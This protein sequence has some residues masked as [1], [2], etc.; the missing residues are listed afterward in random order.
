MIGRALCLFSLALSVSACSSLPTIT[1]ELARHSRP[2]VQIDG[3]RGPL[4]AAQSKAVLEGLQRGGKQS[5]L[6]ERHLALEQ[7]IVGSPLSTGNEVILLQDGPATYQAMVA[8]IEAARHEQPVVE[9]QLQAPQQ[10][11]P[12]S[13][14]LRHSVLG[15]DQGHL[16]LQGQRNKKR[17]QIFLIA[18]C[19]KDLGPPFYYRLGG[20]PGN[21]GKRE[22]L[23]V[24]DADFQSGPAQLFCKPTVVQQNYEQV[25]ARQLAQTVQKLKGHHFCA[26]PLVT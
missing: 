12:P 2:P 16:V 14:H 7:A 11:R 9:M 22:A 13:L 18:V 25:D 6:F 19:M 26:R 1:P 5:D 17:K 24:E 4:S 8:A 15:T 10:I 23:L 20:L 3:A 21:F